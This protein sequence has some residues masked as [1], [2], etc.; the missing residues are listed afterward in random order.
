M[1]RHWS[2]QQLW[3]HSWAALWRSLY[4]QALCCRPI[5]P[6]L[7][8]S[9]VKSIAITKSLGEFM[10]SLRWYSQDWAGK[11]AGHYYGLFLLL[12]A[13]F[14]Q[15]K[16]QDLLPLELHNP[17]N[18]FSILFTTDIS[19]LRQENYWNAIGVALTA[20][21]ILFLPSWPPRYASLGLFTPN[22]ANP[23]ATF[24]A[25]PGLRQAHL[26]RSAWRW[27]SAAPYNHTPSKAWS[28]CSA[29]NAPWSWAKAPPVIPIPV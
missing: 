11:I 20:V 13:D 21:W 23:S 24:P 25:F 3:Q 14:I 4:L 8:I 22:S 29:I 28:L 18:C 10:E 5:S 1:E 7:R 26:L 6:Y 12:L 9:H 15:G 2:C 17:D 19:F 16:A 27:T